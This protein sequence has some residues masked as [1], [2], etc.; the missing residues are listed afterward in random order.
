[1]ENFDTFLQN[2]YIPIYGITLALSLYRY[3]KYFD[4]K[5]K[6]LPIL[7]LYTFLNELLG[8]L[9]RNYEEFS[10]ISNKIYSDYNWLI[11]NVYT[12]IF[13]FYFYYLYW[14]YT[15]RQ[16]SKKIIFYGAVVFAIVS[17]VNASI[18]DLSK[19]PQVYTYVIGGLLLIYSIIVYLRRFFTIP[20]DFKIKEDILFWISTGLLVFYTGYLPIKIIRYIYTSQGLTPEPIIKRIHLL[21]ILI[22]YTCIIIGFIRMKRRFAK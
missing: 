18:E 16:Q 10:L 1:M 20:R 12:I 17:L 7:F 2:S 9:I 3:P 21:L 22:S 19:I 11:F 6:Y 15:E 13:Y 4:S 14:N 8:R 5:L